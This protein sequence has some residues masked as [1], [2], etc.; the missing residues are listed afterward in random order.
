MKINNLKK[1][2]V[3]S[4]IGLL[5]FLMILTTGTSFAQGTFSKIVGKVVEE[6]TDMPL[7]GA[8]VMIVGTNLGAA[9]D[10]NG[11]FEIMG[12]PR[13]ITL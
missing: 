13:E 1:F 4:I 5:L 10:R 3:E 9:T 7:I 11:N 8:N 6:G 2:K 12:I